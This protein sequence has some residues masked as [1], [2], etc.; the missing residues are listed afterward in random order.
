MIDV[1]HSYLTE[2]GG[3]DIFWTGSRLENLRSPLPK[4]GTK[5]SGSA[6]VPYRYHFNTVTFGY[7]TAFWNFDKWSLLLDWL[8][9]RGVNLPLAWNGYEAILLQAVLTR[10][11]R[12]RKLFR[13]TYRVYPVAGIVQVLCA[14]LRQRITQSVVIL[15]RRTQS[16]PLQDLI[17]TR[18]LPL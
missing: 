1:I 8:A 17:R 5:V 15:S 11:H 2:F 10:L 16:S 12:L 7:T 4:V 3:V 18:R 6:I 14:L 13:V 9:L